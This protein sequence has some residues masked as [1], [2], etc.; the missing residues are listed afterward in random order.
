M[1]I[2]PEIKSVLSSA[3]LNE[4][5]KTIVF[6]SQMDRKTYTTVNEILNTV[7]FT[8]N[9]KAKAHIGTVSPNDALKVILGG[10]SGTIT[11]TLETKKER[12]KAFQF[13]GTPDDLADTL[14]L[15]LQ[16][17]QWM[18]DTILETSGG[19]GSLINAINRWLPNKKVDCYELMPE[20]REVLS[21]IPTANILGDDFFQRDMSVTYDCII[22]NP[23]FSKLQDLDFIRSAY[24]SLNDGGRMVTVSSNGWENSSRKKCKEFVEWLEDVDARVYPIASGAFKE[25]GTMVGANYI[26]FWKI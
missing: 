13:F 11:T 16:W 1:T 17:D 5:T 7:G 22:Q 2:T 18:P 12:K 24:E 9:K 6:T 4:D 14:V 3:T 19:Q 20:N 10:N 26:T 25:S 8:W 15:S 23:P 21:T